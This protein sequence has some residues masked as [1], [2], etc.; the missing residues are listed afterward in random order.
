[1]VIALQSLAL[2]PIDYYLRDFGFVIDDYLAVVGSDV[3]GIIIASGSIAISHKLGTRVAAFP[4]TYFVHGAADDGAFYTK[5]LNPDVNINEASLWGISVVTAWSGLWTISIPLRDTLYTAQDKKGLL[6]WGGASSIGSG[7]V[8]AAKL[9]GFNVYAIASPKHHDHV[10]SLGAQEVFDYKDAEVVD[11][12]VKVAKQD[13]INVQPAFDA[14]GQV[15][16]CLDILKKFKAG[17]TR[18]LATAIPMSD[19]TPKEEEVIVKSVEA[20][21]EAKE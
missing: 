21:T 10:R 16:S 2:N 13:R 15:Q 11:K 12:T 18:Q 19:Q 5:T 7:T 8:Q 20:P 6:V 17:G 9:L 4:P 1:M 3:G 14:A